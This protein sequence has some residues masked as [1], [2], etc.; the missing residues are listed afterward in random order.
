MVGS[1]AG[2]PIVPHKRWPTYVD[3]TN[4]KKRNRFRFSHPLRLTYLLN[5]FGFDAPC[6]LY[7]ASLQYIDDYPASSWMKL[8]RLRAVRERFGKNLNVSRYYNQERLIQVVLKRVPKSLH[9]YLKSFRESRGI[10]MGHE[11]GIHHVH[12][13]FFDTSIIRF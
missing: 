9:C 2:S 13:S 8:W 6:S 1:E 11:L 10:K 4:P 5:N 12:H 7:V 3:P